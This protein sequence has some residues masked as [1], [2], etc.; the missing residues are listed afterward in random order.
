LEYDLLLSAGAD[1]HAV[2]F[3]VTGADKIALDD[4]GNLSLGV[5]G[6]QVGLRAGRDD[7]LRDAAKRYRVDIEKLQKAV[8]KEFAAK[9]DKKT[10]KPKGRKAAA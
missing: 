10:I 9:R 1:P 2:R 3:R 5:A 8:A 7:A 6:G 4:S